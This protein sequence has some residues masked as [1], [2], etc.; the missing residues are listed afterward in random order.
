MYIYIYIYLFNHSVIDA[1]IPLIYVIGS[2]CVLIVAYIKYKRRKFSLYEP[3]IS[4]QIT[5][6]YGAI[7][8]EESNIENDDDSKSTPLTDEYQRNNFFDWGRLFFGVVMF[9]LFCLVGIVRWCDYI[10]NKRE[11]YRITSPIIEVLVW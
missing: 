11:I 9:V 8:S 7:N 5:S 4:G 2:I 6:S 1:G 10:E 3:L